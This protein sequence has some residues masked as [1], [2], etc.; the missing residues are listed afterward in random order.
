MHLLL[1]A[2]SIWDTTEA[3]PGMSNRVHSKILSEIKPAVLRLSAAITGL[4]VDVSHELA[5]TGRVHCRDMETEEQEDVL[6]LLLDL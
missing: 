1:S 2:N 4:F 6:Q 5:S 3:L